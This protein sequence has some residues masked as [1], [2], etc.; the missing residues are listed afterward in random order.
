MPSFKGRAFQIKKGGVVLAG[1]QTKS[2]PIT[3]EPIDITS[4]D[5][6]GFRTYHN[7]AGLRSMDATFEG[8]VKDTVLIELIMSGGTAAMLTDVT[9]NYPNGDVI[10][11]DFF[12]SNLD[13]TGETAG[14]LKFSGT[15]QSSGPFA[16]TAAA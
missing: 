4:D 15:I 9:L 14:A 3:N 7:E 13:Y 5:D 10:A 6:S 2:A 1:V 16:R 11:G 8:V 12:L